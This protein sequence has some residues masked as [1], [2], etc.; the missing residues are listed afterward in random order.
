ME[1]FRIFLDTDVL[2]NWLVMETDPNT[3]FNLWRCPYEIVELIEEGQIEGHTSLTNIFEVRFVLRGKKRYGEKKIK[4]CMESLF[5]LIE[6]EVPDSGDMLEAN[7][8]QSEQP[9][10]PFDSI[11][12]SII[13]VKSAILVSRDDDFIRHAN[14]LNV[15]VY[16]PEEFLAKYFPIIFERI[17]ADLGITEEK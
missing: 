9:L 14:K 12:L 8:L 16:T 4:E 3:R 11:G 6:I 15:G 2:I 5:R 1:S 17:K 10:D 13:L 7:R